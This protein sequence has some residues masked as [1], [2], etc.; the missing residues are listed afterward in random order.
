MHRLPPAWI[1]FSAGAGFFVA[2]VALTIAALVQSTPLAIAVL[3]VSLGA[4]GVVQ[5]QVWAACQ[6][7]GGSHSATLTGFTNL[8]GN[9]TAAAGPI[10]T[11]CSSASAGTGGWHWR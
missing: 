4:V 9:L 5:V 1:R 11:A 8:C 7:L 10:F 2:A 6:D 3:C